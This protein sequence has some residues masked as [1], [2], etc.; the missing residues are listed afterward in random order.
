MHTFK[1]IIKFFK[2]FLKYCSTRDLPPL[3]LNCLTE[4]QNALFP[5]RKGCGLYVV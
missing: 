5:Y 3:P 4:A 2:I 1:N